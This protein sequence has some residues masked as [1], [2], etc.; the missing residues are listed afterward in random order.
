MVRQDYE[1]LLE[2]FYRD[3]VERN[4]E[5]NLT[6]I[7]DEKEFHV[8]HFEDSLSLEKACEDVSRETFTVIDVG[9][10]AGFPGM[11][12]AIKYPNLKITM[13]DSLRKRIDF[14]NEEIEKLGL[15]NCRAIHA[16][17]EDLARDPGYREKFDM[18][19]SR[20]VANLSTLSEYVL[21]FIHIGGH[22][23]AYKAGG[24]KDECQ[25][26]ERALAKLGGSLINTTFFE[27]S[28]GMGERA[29]LDIK[30]L[31]TTPD[32]YPRKAGTPSKKPL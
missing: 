10:G 19:V 3:V 9:T 18:G 29:I 30:K 28:D 26:A 14:I 8:K 15:E 1:Q 16:R 12:L 2:A 6:S 4:K 27:L 21:P 31:S 25:G 7:T 5:F 20:A 13:M 17:A 23:Y 11:P 22:F 32:T 24:C